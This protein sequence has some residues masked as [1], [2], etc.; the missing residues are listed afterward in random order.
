VTT[1]LQSV[2]SNFAAPQQSGNPDG[3]LM[4]RNNGDE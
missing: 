2:N 1:L 3:V 4:V